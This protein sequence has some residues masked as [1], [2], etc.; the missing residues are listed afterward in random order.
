MTKL[1]RS[2]HTMPGA[3]LGPE[4]PLPDF[5]NVAG[6]R[7]P[8]PV[9]VSISEEERKY[10]DY[11]HV[12]HILP[13]RLQDGYSRDKQIRDYPCVVLENDHL[14]ATFFPQ[15]GG[16]LWSLFDKH[17]GRDLLQVNPVLQPCNLALRNAWTS[18]G[19]EW[20]VGIRGHS[21]FTLSQLHTAFGQLSDG[22]PVLRMYEWE[23]VRQVLY[24]LDFLLPED[25]R[26]LQVRVRLQNTSD[27]ETPI[28]W[29][30]NTAVVQTPHTRVLAPA[31]S[32][33]THTYTHGITKIPVP[34]YRGVD[35]SYSM[36][37]RNAQDFFFDIPP[38]RRKWECAVNEAGTGLIH[39]STDLLQGRKLFVWGNSEGGDHWQEFLSVPDGEGYLEIQAGLAN[40]QFECL[41][42]AGGAAWEW[43]EAYG[44]ICADPAI[45]HGDWIRA[46]AHAEALLERALPRKSMDA[47]LEKYRRELDA[48][49]PVEIHGSGWAA[50]ELRRQGGEQSF[51]GTR[52]LLDPDSLTEEQAP[53]LQL[54]EQGTFPDQ[55]IT[56]F[57]AA[58]L[59]QKEWI[60]LLDRAARGSSDHWHSWFHLGV[61]HYAA[62]ACGLA[63]EA[64]ERS[65]SRRENGWSLRCLALLDRKEQKL[66]AA[67]DSM[68]RAAELLPNVHILKEYGRLL[69]EGGR[70]Q[71]YLTLYRGLSP[72][73]QANGRLRALVVEAL[74][75]GG[76]LLEAKT[77]LEAGVEIPDIQEC[78][79]LLSEMWTR[80]HGAL[81]AQE[82]GMPPGPELEKLALERWPVPRHLDFR[83]IIT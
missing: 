65:I 6:Q 28:Y 79:V 71:E 74:T 4:N 69:L 62:G 53:W 21:P 25:S 77:I 61:M 24:Q 26:F 46:T 5:G 11:G 10:V 40:T 29:W 34:M 45:A 58:Y 55:E 82:T 32:C 75:T 7:S 50:L 1:Y 44:P 14:K 56:H 51:P 22:T 73:L 78:E 20:N 19:V 41:P 76:R 72:Q 27:S 60:P 70:W 81:L 59:T 31:D 23:R 16:K 54:L 17:L 83:M 64:F 3:D 37:L 13:Y 49:F 35:C 66:A 67:I 57:P 43:L 68:A 42:M 36:R 9:D 33:F 30:S 48:A 12:E 52:A 80:I 63:R 38:Q 39:T 47:L 15:F 2:L 18:G 8:T